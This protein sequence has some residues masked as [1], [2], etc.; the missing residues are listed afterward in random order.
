V[1]LV[2]FRLGLRRRAGDSGLDPLGDP[3]ISLTQEFS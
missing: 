2:V 1:A 3:L